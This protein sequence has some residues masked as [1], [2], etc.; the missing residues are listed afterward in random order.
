MKNKKI[1]QKDSCIS[2]FYFN[3]FLLAP[4][5]RI[6]FSKLPRN[7]GGKKEFRGKC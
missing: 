7:E 3:Y 1:M 2:A 6:Y 5:C 4:G